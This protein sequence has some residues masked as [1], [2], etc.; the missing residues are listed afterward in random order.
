MVL[1]KTN[2]TNT[3]YSCNKIAKHKRSIPVAI[4]HGIE[5]LVDII[6]AKVVSDKLVNLDLASQVVLDKAGQLGAAL[7][8]TKSRSAPDTAS[9]QLEGTC[10]NLLS[11]SCNSNNDRLAP[12]L[13]ASL[14]VIYN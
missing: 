2:R 10:G 11:C 7:D 13:V 12:S 8:T 6:K 14:F 1:V 9:H 3:K 5:S 4:V